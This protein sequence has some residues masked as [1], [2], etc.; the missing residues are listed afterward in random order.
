M[1]RCGLNS[2]L[3]CYLLKSFE[4]A[5]MVFEDALV[6]QPKYAIT[7]ST[8]SVKWDAERYR[9]G[10]EDLLRE[11]RSEFGRVEML[12]FMEQTTGQAP[13]SGGHKRGH[14]H[15]LVKMDDGGLVLELEKLTKSIWKRKLGAWHVRVVELQSA[16]GAVNY[17]TLNL[18]LEKGK[19][20]QA[21]V[22]LP[23]GTRTLRPTRNYWS[24]PVAE[25]RERAKDHN[26]LKRLR[27]ALAV[28]LSDD[29][30]EVDGAFFELA[31]EAEWERQKAQT[32]ELWKVNELAGA[33]VFEP[34]EPLEG[35]QVEGLVW[36][37]GDLVNVTSGEVWT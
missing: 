14:G 28:E 32:W 22:N 20:A 3:G 26:A 5:Q 11:C 9:R 37:K 10:K 7:L 15:N 17:L 34:I 24:V 13:R 2:C 31:V 16:G 4:R 23:K 33:S 1:V 19:A 27:H 6:E 36:R 21:P 29:R 18:V 8:R 30:G 12:E 25:L 35:Q